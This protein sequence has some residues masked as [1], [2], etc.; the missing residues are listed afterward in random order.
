MKNSPYLDQPTRTLDA[1]L[2]ER[3]DGG[4]SAQPSLRQHFRRHRTGLVTASLLLMGTLLTA[5]YFI[6]LPSGVTDVEIS[7]ED[8]RK[9]S[10]ISP[11]AGPAQD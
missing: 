1:V 3:G 6:F 2:K 5:L 8:I 9:L 11:A 4:V 7:A 10:E